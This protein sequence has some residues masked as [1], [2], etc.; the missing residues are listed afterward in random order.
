MRDER[1]EHGPPGGGAGAAHER[2]PARPRQRARQQ[3]HRRACRAPQVELL[4]APHQLRAACGPDGDYETTRSLLNT[5]CADVQGGGSIE[6]RATRCRTLLP[7]GHDCKTNV[8]IYDTRISKRSSFTKC[9]AHNLFLEIFR[10]KTSVVRNYCAVKS[11][12][13]FYNFEQ[14]NSIYI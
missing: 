10:T 3:R 14:N 8:W 2:L 4:G 13:V 11:L 5:H 6:I 1:G 7:K 9:M 12:T